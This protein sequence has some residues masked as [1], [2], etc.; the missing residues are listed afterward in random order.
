VILEHAEWLLFAWVLGNQGGLPVSPGA[1][2]GMSRQRG[3]ADRGLDAD[4]GDSHRSRASLSA[5]GY[6][7]GWSEPVIRLWNETPHGGRINPAQVR[8]HGEEAR[9]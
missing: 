2:A 5:V 4:A 8:G 9:R 6:E 3:S 7:H 1:R